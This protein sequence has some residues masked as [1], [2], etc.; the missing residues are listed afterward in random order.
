MPK[1]KT[2]KATSK[3][4]TVT[5]TGKIMKRTAGQ[6]HFNARENGKTGRNKK[7][8]VVTSQTL[9]RVMQINLPNS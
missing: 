8:D 3:R 1:L 2:H 5:K 4:Y 6:N 7:S 9:R